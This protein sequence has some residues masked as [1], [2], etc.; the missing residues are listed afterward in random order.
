[1]PFFSETRAMLD[2]VQKELASG[3]GKAI[4]V[5]KG[6]LSKLRAG[7]ATPAL[8]EGVRVEPLG[9]EPAEAAQ[10][11]IRHSMKLYR[12]KFIT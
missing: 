10:E 1:M 5:L 4:E 11:T 8:L 3:I 2:D 12:E 6:E 7:R 9:W